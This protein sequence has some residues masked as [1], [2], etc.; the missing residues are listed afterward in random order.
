MKCPKCE[1]YM[2]KERCYDYVRHFD[3]LRCIACGELVDITIIANR[4]K[5]LNV[6]LG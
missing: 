2:I 3:S 5:S 6:F 1:G 4:A